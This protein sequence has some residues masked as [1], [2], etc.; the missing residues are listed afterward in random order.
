MENNT[1][2]CPNDYPYEIFKTKECIK[3]VESTDTKCPVGYPYVFNYI[4]YE[5]TCPEFSKT[6][7][8]TKFCIC[9]ETKGLWYNKI[10]PDNEKLYLYCGKE[11][12]PNND[13]NKPNLLE[14]KNNALLIVMKTVKRF[15]YIVLEIYVMK[16]VLNLQRRMKHKKN[17]FFIN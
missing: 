8:S 9:D 11:E 17:V 6:K 14:K 12:C 7:G 16:N 2:I 1:L 4:C 3:P 15:L 13:P 10:N 5:N